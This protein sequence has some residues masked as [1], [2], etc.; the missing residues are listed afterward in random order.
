MFLPRKPHGQRILEGYSPWGCKRVR[1]DLATKQQFPSP[2][3]VSGFFVCVFWVYLF[4]L[5]VS[6]AQILHAANLFAPSPPSPSLPLSVT[7][8]PLHFRCPA[9]RDILT[10][11][12]PPFHSLLPLLSQCIFTFPFLVFLCLSRSRVLG[13]S[14]WYWERRT[15]GGSM[16]QDKGLTTRYSWRVFLFEGRLLN[17]DQVVVVHCSTF[18]GTW[19]YSHHCRVKGEQKNWMEHIQNYLKHKIGKWSDSTKILPEKHWRR[20]S[21]ML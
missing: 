14:T 13:P 19:E 16:K 10:V 2:L 17:V 20:N 7:H 15:E 11:I 21:R 12:T 9:Q 6:A 5:I 8:H 3:V 1:H 18:D 4:T